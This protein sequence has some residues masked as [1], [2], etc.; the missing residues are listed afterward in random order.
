MKLK[1]SDCGSLEMPAQLLVTMMIVAATASV[2]LGALSAYSRS[3]V[4]G[5]LRQ[6]AESVAAAAARVDS[7]GLGSSLQITVKLENAP[8]EKLQYFKM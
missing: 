3:T 8:M 1:T 6:Q 4:E 5:A 2:G 7:I